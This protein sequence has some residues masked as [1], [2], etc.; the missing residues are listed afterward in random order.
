MNRS[1]QLA[2][3]AVIRMLRAWLLLLLPL[4]LL[5]FAM[6]SLG[7]T[8]EQL[9]AEGKLQAT[10]VIDTQG[11][12]YQRAPLVLAVE[13]ATSRWFSRGTRVADFRV[14]NAIVQAVSAFADNQSQLRSAESWSIQRWRFRVYPQ[15]DGTLTLPSIPVF[16]SVNSADY[17]IVEGELKLHAPALRIE[18]PSG[19]DSAGEWLATSALEIEDSW[20]GIQ[21]VYQPGDAISRVRRFSIKDAP[22]MLIDERVIDDI[23]GLSLYR[24]PAQLRDERSRGQ[25]SG[26]REET[27]IVT[28]ETAGDFT[29]PGATYTWFNTDSGETRHIVLAAYS[30][31]VENPA[32]GKSA[33]EA[34]GAT[35]SSSYWY[36]RVL[37][38]LASVLFA[39]FIWL[40]IRQIMRSAAFG[41]VSARFRAALHNPLHYYLRYH[42]NYQK[43]KANYRGAIKAQDARQCLELLYAQL[44]QGSSYRSLDKAVAHHQLAHACLRQLLA[45]AYAPEYQG[46][47]P[48]REAL[49]GLWQVVH[50]ASAQRTGAVFR[51][52]VASHHADT[53]PKNSL[54]INPPPTQS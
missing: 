25:L 44:C 41:R 54:R 23:P 4:V 35:R 11:P 48:D 52:R 3:A 51:R 46:D 33:A 40:C 36:L 29:I 47:F 2:F 10:V 49:Q 16:I 24:A 13:I 15:R 31:S 14:D 37:P 32:G 17:G 30:F 19:V 5:P 39:T 7:A 28:A 12:L 27:L 20:E 43:A 21:Q 26:V 6:Q 38:L 53:M 50:A 8:P 22:A 1:P 34:G 42:L 9:I 45:C 18:T